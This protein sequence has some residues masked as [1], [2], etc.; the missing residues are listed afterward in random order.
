MAALVGAPAVAAALWAAAAGGAQA[1]EAAEAAARY[2]PSPMEPGWE[3]WAGLVAGVVPFI[4]ASYEFGKRIL[5]QRRCPECGGKGLV[6]RGSKRKLRKCPEVRA[7]LGGCSVCMFR[8]VPR[9][10]T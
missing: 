2:T 3:I 6:E 5:I 7:L 8:R 1:A 10:H 4:I 9:S